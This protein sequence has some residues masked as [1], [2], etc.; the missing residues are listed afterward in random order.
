MGHDISAYLGAAD[1]ADPEEQ[2]DN[3][4]DLPEVAYLRRNAYNPLRH[5]LYEVLGAQEYDGDVSGIWAARWFDRD[6]LLAALQQLLQ[7]L[8]TGQ[9]VQPE[10]DFLEACLAAL[11]PDRTSVFIT[12]G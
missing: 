2:L 11:P 7:R 8:A 4:S 5:T 10:I 6:Q 12:F 3:W 9:E 1:P